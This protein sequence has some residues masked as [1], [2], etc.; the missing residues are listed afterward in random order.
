MKKIQILASV[1][2]LVLISGSAMA[3]EKIWGGVGSGLY[4]AK[5]HT[6]GQISTD[7]AHYGTRAN[8]GRGC[9]KIFTFHGTCGAMARGTKGAWGFGKA[10]IKSDAELGA[11][12]A[13]LMHGSD[14]KVQVSTCS[15]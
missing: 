1:V 7:A 5:G 13:C 11:I 10:A 15:G 4:G 3:G 6:Q 9:Q 8:C 2:S 12:S 14:C